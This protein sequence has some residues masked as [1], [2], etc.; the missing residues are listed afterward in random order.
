MKN[1][2]SEFPELVKNGEA[3]LIT[4]RGVSVARIESVRSIRTRLA[5]KRVSRLESAGA[6]ST[7]PEDEELA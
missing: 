1:G 3:I 2:L 4:D 5:N 7:W 6:A